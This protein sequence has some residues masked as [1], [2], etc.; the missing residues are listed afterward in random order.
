MAVLLP[1]DQLLELWPDEFRGIRVGALLHPASVN[2]KL[3]HS[4]RIFERENGRLFHLRAL[5]GPQHGYRGETQDNM[6]EWRSYEHPRLGI[7]VYSLYGEHREPTREML[8]NLDLFLIDLQDI[9]TRY[10]TFIWTLYLAIRACEREN[11]QVIVLDRPNPINGITVEGPRLNPDYR[12]FVGMH[13]IRV[14]HGKTIG[15]LATQFRDE[16]F[17]KCALTI[18]PMKNSE[19]AMWFDQT[20]LPWVMPSPNMPTLDTATVYPGMCLLEGTNVSERR[21]TTR[22]FEFVGAPFLDAYALAGGLTD[23]KLPGGC[24][25]PHYFTPT[26]DKHKGARCV[27]VQLHLTDRDAFKSYVTGIAVVK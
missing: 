25:R 4:A 12:S 6:I 21:G 27:C 11:V 7:P 16:S 15:E 13:P 19:R 24:F 9:G 20:G 5:F 26:W 2:S 3:E 23:E 18:L 1:V 8:Q 14:R 17:P 22:P 10:Y